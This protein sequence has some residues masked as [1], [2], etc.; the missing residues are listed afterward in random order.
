MSSLIFQCTFVLVS[1]LEFQIQSLYTIVKSLYG[2]LQS[3][4]FWMQLMIFLFQLVNPIILS[5]RIIYINLKSC[6]SA[7]TSHVFLGDPP[8]IEAISVPNET[9]AIWLRKVCC[10]TFLTTVLCRPRRLQ[11]LGVVQTLP[12]FL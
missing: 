11:W 4:I 10:Q 12:T 1:H 2:L 5:P 6:L 3:D 7:L 8:R 9:L